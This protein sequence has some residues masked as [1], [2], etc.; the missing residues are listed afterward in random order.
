[1]NRMPSA[2]TLFDLRLLPG[3]SLAILVNT[4]QLSRMKFQQLE[5]LLSA[6]EKYQYFSKVS[7]QEH[8]RCCATRIALRLI[9]GKLTQLPPAQ[10]R[11]AN[12]DFG[13][14]YLASCKKIRFNVSHSNEFSLLAFAE[15]AEIGCDIE[16]ITQL[17]ELQTMSDLV[18]HPE[19]AAAMSN[20]HGCAL[21]EAFFRTWVRK[22]AVLKAIGVGFSADPRRI[23]V[24]L[25]E[26]EIQVT[27]TDDGISSSLYLH[28]MRPNKNYIAA[29]AS[30]HLSCSWHTLSI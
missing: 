9:L 16:R 30:P 21:Q 10:I 20:L 19:E 28:C 22:E 12:G 7:P 1:M 6:D 8:F 26:S 5:S 24:G 3:T 29:V 14:P 18:L 4:A 23:R 15:E 25:I 17:E 13:K 27:H 11:F 2:I